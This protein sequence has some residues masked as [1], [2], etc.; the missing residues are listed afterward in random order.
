MTQPYY[1]YAQQIV[2]RKDERGIRQLSDFKGKPVEIYQPPPRC[3][4]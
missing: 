4:P 2:T 1:I 3:V